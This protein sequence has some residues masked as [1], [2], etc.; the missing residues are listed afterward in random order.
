MIRRWKYFFQN[1]QLKNKVLLIFSVAGIFPLLLLT[2]FSLVIIQYFTL[3]TE[4][5]KNEDNLLSAYQ[6]LN[7]T[8]SSYED[9]LAFLVNND[10]LDREL[11][12]KDPT[13]YDQYNL[14]IY[15]IVPLF[16]SITA[17]QPDIQ[18]IT[19]YTTLDV[20][21]HGEF[22][23]KIE[24][25]DITR[26][27]TFD[28]KTSTEYFYDKPNDRMYLYSQLFSRN[29][30]EKHVIVFDIDPNTLFGNI[31]PI[32][33]ESYTLSIQD[34]YGRDLF[35]RTQK[36]DDRS[37][38]LF[39]KLLAAFYPGDD[40]Y[41]KTLS[42][43]WVVQFRR[44]L[45]TMYHGTL[46]LILFA[47]SLL[48]ISLLLVFVAIWSLNKT[49]VSPLQTLSKE[50]GTIDEQDFLKHQLT[51]EA[52]DEIGQLYHE[53]NQ[54]LSTIHTLIDDVYQGEINQKKH[55][56]RALQAQ[57]NPH[58]FYNSLSLINNKAVMIGNQEISEMAQ[59][60]STFYR[61]SLNNGK[62]RLSVK[63]ELD[64]TIAY[65]Q[66]QLKM[67]RDS[68]DLVTEIDEQ[69]YSYEIMNL[70]IQPFVENAIF[71][72]IDHIEDE[73]RG[74]LLL[75]GYATAHSIYIEVSDNGAGMDNE[76]IATILKSQQGEHYGIYNIQQRMALYYGTRGSI[77]YHSQIGIGTK[78]TIRLPKIM[79]E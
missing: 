12:L 56:L 9:A 50:M 66:I 17:L 52:K 26:F 41:Q 67:H 8:L 54:M 30:K 1:L 32:S 62:N 55:E 49:V 79:T 15:T 25:D 2:I 39:P 65:A 24:K 36:P 75:K 33:E 27:F 78:V 11:S 73:R 61:L 5:N 18:N 70:L 71:H 37:N 7:A 13:N 77:A 58:F 40:R 35:Y 21:N 3:Q 38:Q 64:L 22:V 42:N 51:Y 45:A 20:Y 29:S 76:Q 48:L 43:G 31:S 6:Q 72:G 59:L 69:I 60:L 57:I 68:F 4:R 28:K 19:L 46:L 10:Q 23:R 53:F 34:R 44:P 16:N 14:Y 47:T 74:R 63:Q